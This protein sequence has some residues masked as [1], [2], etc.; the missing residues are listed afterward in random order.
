M[1]RAR[2]EGRREGGDTPSH[3]RRAPADRLCNLIAP[4][5]AIAES[6][7]REGYESALAEAGLGLDES[8][9]VEASEPNAS[10]AREPARRLLRRGDRPTAV[11]CFSDRLA[12]GFYQVAAE[13]GLQIP[14]DL[15]IVGFDNQQNFAENLFPGLTTVQLPHYRMGVRAAE[16]AIAR[17]Q[18]GGDGPTGH[19]V[20]CPLV[21]RDSV[22][23]PSGRTPKKLTAHR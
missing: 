14:R 19:F 11:F 10:A 23:A 13:L 2:R 22:A 21:I 18:D 16:K 12:L 4:A 5:F 17:L 9:V 1:G 3:R 15:S 7:R 8:L 6:L 20:S